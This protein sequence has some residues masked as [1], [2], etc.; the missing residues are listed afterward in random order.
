MFH[1]VIH[2]SISGIVLVVVL[3]GCLRAQQPTAIIPTSYE[4]RIKT[5]TESEKFKYYPVD[6]PGPQ[7][8]GGRVTDIEVDPTN[9][10]HFYV[11]FASG[12]VWETRNHGASFV[13]VSDLLPT[14][15]VGDL[16]VH[17]KSGIIY[18]GTGEV[19]SSRS[20]YAGMGVY[21]SENG[22]KTWEYRGLP[23]S[24]HIGRILVD[25]E[26]P[27]KVTVAVLGKLYVSSADRGIYQTVDGGKSWNHTLKINNETGCV[28]LV[29]D[30]NRRE[31][32]Y[33]SA[34]ERSRKAW[35]FE[36]SGKGSG[37]YKSVDGGQSWIKVS[38]SESGFPDGNFVGRIGL[39]LGKD[40]IYAVLDNQLPLEK[41][42]TPGLKRKDFLTMEVS[43]FLGLSDSVL[44]E[45][46]EISNFP[47]EYSPKRLKTMVKA[48]S[49]K[50]VD[51]YR[52]LSDANSDLFEASAR[53]V[54]LYVSFDEGK[55]WKKTHETSLNKVA[56]SY[57]YYFGLVSCNFQQ[58]ER[59]YIAGVPMLRSEDGGRSFEFAG[60]DEVHVD[61]HVLWINPND[62]DHIVNG[63]DGG[64]NISYDGG[65]NWLRCHH[66]PV[67]QFYSVYADEEKPYRIYGGLQDNGVWR[68]VSGSEQGDGWLQTGQNAWNM[69]MGGDG[70][71]VARSAREQAVYT[72]YQF[73]FYYRIDEKTGNRTS[74]KPQHKLGE[75]PLRFNWQTPI[76]LSVHNSEI[77]YYG[78][79]KVHR[80]LNG[81]RDWAD[82]S[83]DLTRGGK[84]GDVSFGTI[85]SLKESERQFGWLLV[86]TD[87]GRIWLSTNG[88]NQWQE[89]GKEIGREF[90]ISRVLFSRHRDSTIYVT[91]N[92]YRNDYFEPMLYRSRDLGKTW[93]KLKG[94]PTSPVNAICE[95]RFDEQIIYVGTDNGFFLS[96][97]GGSSF[98]NGPG[99]IPMVAVH[100]I[101]QQKEGDV[102]LGTHGRSII[103]MK[104]NWIHEVKKGAWT[105]SVITPAITKVSKQRGKQQFDF[106]YES[107]EIEIGVYNPMASDSAIIEVLDSSRVVFYRGK[108]WLAKGFSSVKWDQAINQTV[109]IGEIPESDDKRKYLPTGKYKVRLVMGEAKAERV[110]V[111]K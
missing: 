105:F 99:E 39:S 70:M 10:A 36:E 62:P 97:D 91:V 52:F 47:V 9:S 102:L 60:G 20:S 94:L 51:I 72:G 101:F 38:H 68:S 66:P 31:I 16:A 37:I 79:N 12:G 40:R 95:D 14:L 45:F 23:E 5:T 69:I 100:D 15:T 25:S 83:G 104:S 88:G 56:Y 82:I 73:G 59:V 2:K 81:G 98:L 3:Q 107:Q 27:N 84:R 58:P 90:W 92:G 65:R 18:I 77:I 29:T 49:I 1:H 43:T 8:M 28:D 96:T 26:N 85:T 61:H 22:G 103:R 111:L 53:G 109:G 24:H 67:G 80:S 71:Q 63:N 75:S 41:E 42:L 48:D 6:H 44:S 30:P 57:G 89:I 17:W 46:L 33:A 55:T 50:V 21:R 106:T 13:S 32:M 87:D 54:E 108:V 35:N 34:W 11:A 74:I 86:G 7:V 4:Q 93:E 78:S 64:V 110:W 76:C 19:N